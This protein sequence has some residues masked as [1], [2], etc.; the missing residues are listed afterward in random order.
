[1]DFRYQFH[2]DHAERIRRWKNSFQAVV[3]NVCSINVFGVHPQA[4]RSCWW[5]KDVHVRIG[6]AMRSL[7]VILFTCSTAFAQAGFPGFLKRAEP[8]A[9]LS[10]SNSAQTVAIPGAGTFVKITGWTSSALNIDVAFAGDSL[11]F[12]RGGVYLVVASFSVDGQTAA[13]SFVFLAAVNGVKITTYQGEF[14]AATANAT[15]S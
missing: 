1:M 8:V 12:T 2:I 9:T 3:G 13:D 6:I 15:Y 5:I 10:M 14:D 11:K 4:R 7:L